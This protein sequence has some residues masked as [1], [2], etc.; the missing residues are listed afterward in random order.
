MMDDKQIRKIRNSYNS[1]RVGSE[2]G[3][4]FGESRQFLHL[5]RQLLVLPANCRDHLK[6]QQLFEISKKK[7]T[8]SKSCC[9]NASLFMGS[10]VMLP[11]K[12]RASRISVMNSET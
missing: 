4:Q 1:I 3:I 11:S 12:L 10:T 2:C 8:F 9:L 5:L 6:N 7:P